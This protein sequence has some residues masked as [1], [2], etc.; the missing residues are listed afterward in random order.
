MALEPAVRRGRRK[1][2]CGALE[3]AAAILGAVAASVLA[4]GL[5]GPYIAALT[6]SSHVP[7]PVL[8]SVATSALILALVAATGSMGLR[9][10][11]RRIEDDGLAAQPLINP[12]MAAG[13][14]KPSAG[15]STPWT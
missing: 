2:T 9:G 6:G 15:D 4:V 3:Q 1:F 13:E 12:A 14:D 10:L 5:V 11:A 7:P 8:V